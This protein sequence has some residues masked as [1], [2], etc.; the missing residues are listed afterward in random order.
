MMRKRESSKYSSSLVSQCWFNKIHLD[1]KPFQGCILITIFLAVVFFCF[2]FFNFFTDNRKLF[3]S[4]RLN[5]NWCT[6]FSNGINK[7]VLQNYLGG[8]VPKMLL[9]YQLIR[10]YLLISSTYCYNALVGAGYLIL[11]YCYCLFFSKDWVFECCK[12]QL[13]VPRCYTLRN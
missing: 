3:Q 4:L 8:G 11:L 10:W 12:M 6:F 7:T 13:G 2:V 9:R 5:W 1:K